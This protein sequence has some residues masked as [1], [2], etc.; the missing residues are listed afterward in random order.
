MSLFLRWSSASRDTSSIP[1]PGEFCRRLC[2][3]YHW[4]RR[5]V[6]VIVDCCMPETKDTPLPHSLSL[7]R[8][9]LSLLGIYRLPFS[10]P[11][12]AALVIQ[13]VLPTSVQ[14]KIRTV[15]GHV[16]FDAGISA[17]SALRRPTA[18]EFRCKCSAAREQFG[19]RSHGTVHPRLAGVRLRHFFSL[20]AL[21]VL[22]PSSSWLRGCRRYRHRAASVRRRLVAL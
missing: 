10:C 6:L 20:S 3:Q 17:I 2:M 22:S 11:S 15:V 5:R 13:N 1:P 14:N 19:R 4:S 21:R 8:V 18:L 7:S 9:S 12:G 16:D